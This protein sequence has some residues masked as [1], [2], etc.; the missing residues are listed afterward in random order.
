M[1][2]WHCTTRTNTLHQPGI[3]RTHP[4]SKY[5]LD[6]DLTPVISIHQTSSTTPCLYSVPPFY[7]LMPC[8]LIVIIVGYACPSALSPNTTQCVA[9]PPCMSPL[10]PLHAIPFL[11]RRFLWNNSWWWPPLTKCIGNLLGVLWVLLFVVLN[12]RCC[13]DMST[14]KYKHCSF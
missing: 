2:P 3:T 13:L 10:S 9:C 14:S 1:V 5:S 6:R 8:T 4:P 11:Q 7:L 12:W